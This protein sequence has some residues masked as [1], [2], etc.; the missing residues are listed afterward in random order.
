MVGA[1]EEGGRSDF[2]GG[3]PASLEDGVEEAGKLFFR[4]HAQ[5]FGEDSAEIL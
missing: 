5:A 4:R 1:E 3:L 2:S